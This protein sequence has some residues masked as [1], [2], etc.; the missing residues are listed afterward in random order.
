MIILVKRNSLDDGEWDEDLGISY[1]KPIKDVIGVREVAQTR[2]SAHKEEGNGAAKKGIE[3]K[4]K[5]NE[6]W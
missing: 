4:D 6:D 5:I 3:G 1:E 2:G